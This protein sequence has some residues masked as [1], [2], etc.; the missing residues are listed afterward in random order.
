MQATLALY[1]PSGYVL[2]PTDWAKIELL[3]DS[4][5]RYLIGSPLGSV[6]PHLWGLP[7]VATPAIQAT[8]F[9][10]GAF[11]LGAQIFDRM[12]IEVVIST[13]NEDDF[14]K[15]LVTIRCEERLALAVYRPAA[16]ITGTLP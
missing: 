2:H 1:P 8:K 16:F 6:T 10:T 13:E 5:Q 15:N 4:T 14:V 12:A 9:L 7:V 3:K 11:K